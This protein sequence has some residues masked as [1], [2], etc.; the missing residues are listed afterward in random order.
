[1]MT[2]PTPR[3]DTPA[4]GSV[5]EVDEV[6]VEY[7][8]KGWRTPPFRA[9]HGVSLDIRAGETVGLVGESGSG[10]TTLGR[11]VLGLAPVREGRIAYAGRDISRLGARERRALSD[12]I[13]VVFQDPYTSLNPAMT[14]GDILTEPLLVAGVSRG[15]AGE[16]IRELLDQVSLPA[17]AAHRLPREFSGGQ[18]QRIAIAR[19]LC[20]DPRLIVCDEPVSALDLSTQAR[21]LDLFIE[22]QERT[23]VAYLFITHDLSVV[24]RISHRVAVMYR[25]EIV[26]SGDTRAVTSQ[27]QHPYTQRLMLAAL[28]PDPDRQRDRREQR[29]GLAAAGS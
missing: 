26:E 9:L 17:D 19:A 12:E 13:Q 11:A 25:G 4:H 5:L 8:A 27:P 14:V 6:V 18:R 20:R 2:N 10:K 16:R 1:M 3:P 24:R 22:I 23:G 7:P 21:V 28:V 29:R 15:A